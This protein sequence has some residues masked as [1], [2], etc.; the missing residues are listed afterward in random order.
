MFEGI[1]YTTK[2]TGKWQLEKSWSVSDSA[3]M[4]LMPASLFT[5]YGICDH[6]EVC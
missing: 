6:E 2:N 4:E 3:G 5:P 1:T